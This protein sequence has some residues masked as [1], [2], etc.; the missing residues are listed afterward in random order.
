MFFHKDLN[1]LLPLIIF[2][3][4]GFHV[5][6]TIIFS[7]ENFQISELKTCTEYWDESHS[8]ACNPQNKNSPKIEKVLQSNYCL[9][10]YFT[11]TTYFTDIISTY[12][13]CHTIHQLLFIPFI[14]VEKGHDASRI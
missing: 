13:D 2:Y 9:Y 1:N 10:F 11:T 5:S 4:V 6:S 12:Q 7:Y 8:F 3:A 14:I